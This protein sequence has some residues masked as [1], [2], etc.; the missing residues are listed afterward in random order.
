MFSPLIDQLIN[1]LRCLPGIGPKSAQRMAFQLLQHQRESGLN[2]AHILQRAISEVG[3]CHQCHTLCETALCRLCADTRR[4]QTLLCIVESPANVIAFEQTGSYRGLY[5]V[6]TRLLSPLDGVGPQEIG[7]D[8]LLMRI[9][10]GGI[11]EIIL[12]TNM[13]VEGKATA[14]YIAQMLEEL[15]IKCTRIACGV[16]VGGDLEFLDANTLALA[17]DA[18]TPLQR[19][20]S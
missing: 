8:R 5:F 15:P 18:R 3:H 12:A 17:F 20:S 10:Q 6:L 4:D 1:A 7:L 13:T 14:H 11:Q 19:S 16:P 2:L 9:R